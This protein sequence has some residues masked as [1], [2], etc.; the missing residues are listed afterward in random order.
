M[1]N[2]PQAVLEEITGRLVAEFGPEEIVLFGSHAWGEP[3]TDSD[4][5]I[6]VV[7]SSSEQTPTERA[8]RAYRCVRGIRVPLDILVKTR[9]EAERYRGVR[10]ALA[11]RIRERG[12]V[13]YGR[14]KAVAGS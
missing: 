14:S 2:V 4:V 6:L 12:R 9:G 11:H 10:A 13:L 8:R 7:V 5:D 1:K 3:D